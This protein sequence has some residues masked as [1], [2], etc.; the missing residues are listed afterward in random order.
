MNAEGTK[1][2]VI[3][4]Y[5]EELHFMYLFLKRTIEQEFPGL[6]FER[7]DRQAM[8]GLLKD[9]IVRSI[10]A[11]DVVIADCT[12]ANANVFYEL[13]M[14]HALGKATILLTGERAEGPPTDIRA[15]EFIAYRLD[16]ERHLLDQLRQALRSVLEPTDDDYEQAKRL[17]VSYQQA[18]N[19]NFRPVD[20]A[21][22][23]RRIEHKLQPGDSSV[24]RARI[25]LSEVIDD[26]LTIDDARTMGDWID[27]E[28]P[29]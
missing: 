9:K 22:F 25:I 16:D 29:N 13:G 12:G 20:R 18:T 17:L 10:N 21:E 19:V 24:K 27:Q 7:A 4:P 26:R 11:A 6:V 23:E 3:M 5:R 28:L 8:T 1:V 14:A 15:Y 2:F